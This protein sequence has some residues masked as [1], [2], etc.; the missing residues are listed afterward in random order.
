MSNTKKLDLIIWGATGFTGQLVSQYINKTYSSTL[1]KWGI[2]GRNKEK[3]LTIAR[4]LKIDNENIF[5]ADSNDLESLIK[6]TSK[7]K[8]ICTTVGPYA[9]YGTN[10]IEACIKTYTNYCDITGETQWIRKIIDKYHLKAKENKIKI[11]NSCGFD[12]IPS[13]MGVFYSQKRIFEKTGEYASKINMRVA[14]A[15]GGISGG[16]YNS[17]SNVLDEARVDKE[18]QKTLTNPYGLNPINKQIGSDNVDLQKVIFDKISKSWIAPFVMAGINTKIVRRS[19]ALINFKYG[20][21]FS[22]DEAILTGRGIFGQIKGYMTLIPIF[23]ATRKKG[24]VIKKIVDYFMPKSGEGPSEKTRINGYYNLRFYLT[25]QN[26]IYISKVI[27]DMDP[28]YGSTSKMLAESAVCLAIDKTTEN[29]GIL[30]PSVA[31]GDALLKR[32]K[33]NAGLTFAFD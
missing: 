13:D 7:T 29:Y 1:L 8:V 2:A 21:D 22:Y 9:K 11:I 25:H 23:L 4:K 20:S 24:S 27:G 15:K 17:L 14:S 19:H 30:T 26:K 10:L 12:S 31:L 18:V 5:I 16:T 3:V 33:D 32:L 6:L 28:G